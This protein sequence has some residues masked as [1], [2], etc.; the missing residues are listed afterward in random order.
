MEGKDYLRT[1]ILNAMHGEKQEQI[2][3][4]AKEIENIKYVEEVRREYR[5]ND[6]GEYWF[7]FVTVDN[8]KHIDYVKEKVDDM[9]YD[10]GGGKDAF[11][12]QIDSAQYMQKFVSFVNLL[13]N[14]LTTIMLL[15]F[16]INLLKDEKKD[17]IVLRA[18]GYTSNKIWKIMLVKI[19]LFIII[20]YMLSQIIALLFAP[21]IDTL[22][23]SYGI[24]NYKAYALSH[25][26]IKPLICIS[27]I[28][29]VLGITMYLQI[30]KMDYISNKV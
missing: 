14:A 11:E 30:R 28:V 21:I 6:I 5:N 26:N 29:L 9:G 16:S 17:N 2:D 24:E 23:F 7:Y 4:A 22:L 12:I 13:I 27:F 10:L 8:W 25:L 1:M 19:I 15:L 20:A 3:E 18:T